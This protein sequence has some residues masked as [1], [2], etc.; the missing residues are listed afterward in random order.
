MWENIV[1]FLLLSTVLLYGVQYG[2]LYSMTVSFGPKNKK[3]IKT[4]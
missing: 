4:C 2:V 3:K 1:Q